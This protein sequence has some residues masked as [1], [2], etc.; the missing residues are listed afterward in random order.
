MRQPR[1]TDVAACSDP[2]MFSAP[3][4]L[5]AQHAKLKHWLVAEAYPLWASGGYDHMHGGFQELLDSGGPVACA[6]RRARV[7]VRQI[8]CFARAAGLGWRGDAAK[9]VTRG[10]E[11]FLRRY[12]RADGLFRTLIAAD[13]TVL[14]DRALLYDQAFV[15][16]ALAESCRFLGVT[17]DLDVVTESLLVAIQWR[18]RCAGPGFVEEGTDGQSPLPNPHMHMLEAAQNWSSIDDRGQWHELAEEIIALALDRMIDPRSGALFEPSAG[19]GRQLEPGH[20]YEWAWLLLRCRGS[21]RERAA[22]AAARLI[23]SVE[24]HGVRDSLVIMALSE[25]LIPYDSSA[26]LWSQTER[27]K[28]ALAMMATTKQH[29]YQAMAADAIG[30]LLRY[31]R[32]DAPGLWW[33]RLNAEGEIVREPAPASTFYHLVCAI[34]ELGALTG[35]TG[36]HDA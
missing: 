27:L 36:D 23:H 11:Y 1:S 15:L 6:P 9:L 4:Q 2:E 8:Y 3:A 22:A 5:R 29:D 33:D 10:W 20:Q 14:D 24:R 31:L 13:G 17:P 28:A 7:Q 35:S 19:A 34:G 26:R 18:F 32:A 25:D 21:T 30:M 12:R 16:L